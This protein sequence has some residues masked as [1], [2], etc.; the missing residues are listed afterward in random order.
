MGRLIYGAD[1]FSLAEAKSSAA[2]DSG[3]LIRRPPE[4][5]RDRVLI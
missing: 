4:K 2:P 1:Y 3:F 5:F